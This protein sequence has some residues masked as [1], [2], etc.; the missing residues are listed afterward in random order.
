MDRT[1]GFPK[2]LS[3]CRFLLDWRNGGVVICPDVALTAGESMDIAKTFEPNT[4]LVWRKIADHAEARRILEM[5]PRARLQIVEQQRGMVLPSSARHPVVAGKRILFIGTATSFV[6]DFQGCLGEKIRC[7]PYYK[8]VPVSNGCPYYC[9]YCYLAFVYRNYLPCIKMNI[10]YGRMFEEIRKI[11][12]DADGAAAFNM[13]EMLDSLA[14]DHVTRLTQQLVPY[15]SHLPRGYLML[16]TKSSNVQGLLD[17][18]P[19]PHI[20]VS[21]SLNPQPIIETYELGT[22]SL[23]ERLAAARRCQQHGYRIRLRIDPGILYP[24]WQAG[25]TELVRKA[26][27]LLE[28]ENITL[29]MLRLLP[30]HFPL[31]EQAYG[32]RGSKLREARLTD[33]GSDGKLRYSSRERVAFYRFV[34]STIR[35]LNKRVSIGLCRETPD[36][37]SSL[38]DRCTPGRCNCLIWS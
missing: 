22:A 11:V 27:A 10:N 31:A 15:F 38:H 6:R 36:I 1:D 4:I 37:W 25:Y 12:A 3:S 33:R 20:V 23:D 28:P 21:W 9:L 29:G 13:G 35:D 24:D 16:L 7:A 2:A 19:N 30:G 18:E 34:I 14:L 5:F 17:I 8:L 32:R 26:L